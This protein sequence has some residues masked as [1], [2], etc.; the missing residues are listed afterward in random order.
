MTMP[1]ACLDLLIGRI[2]LTRDGKRIGRIEA[3]KANWKG[4]DLF[5]TEFHLG[6]Y[7]ALERLSALRLGIAVLD[8]IRLRRSGYCIPWDRLD[9]SDP[10]RPRALCSMKE[11]REQHRKS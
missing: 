1:E 9:I 4:E 2:V 11:L 3:I 10:R 8:L 7:A 5:V 6:A